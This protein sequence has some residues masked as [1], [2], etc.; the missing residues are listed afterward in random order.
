[1]SLRGCWSRATTVFISAHQKDTLAN[2]RRI[3]VE[4]DRV[5]LLCFSYVLLD[6]VT[7]SVTDLVYYPFLMYI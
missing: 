4:H 3:N 2:G 1:M 7:D 6:L 5:C